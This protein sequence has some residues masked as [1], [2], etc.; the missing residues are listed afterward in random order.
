MPAVRIAAAAANPMTVLRMVLAPMLLG[1]AP[2]LCGKHSRA[3]RVAS[4]GDPCRGRKPL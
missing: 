1:E 4:C 3:G 2:A